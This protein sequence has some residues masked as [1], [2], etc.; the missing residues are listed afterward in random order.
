[1]EEDRPWWL[2]RI[3]LEGGPVYCK[4]RVKSITNND[5]ANP[6]VSVFL[7]ISVISYSAI[8]MILQ[9]KLSH[10]PISDLHCLSLTIKGSISQTK[11]EI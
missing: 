11:I 1:M 10:N 2:R 6:Q 7:V 3:P 9:I 5:S 4:W 8:S